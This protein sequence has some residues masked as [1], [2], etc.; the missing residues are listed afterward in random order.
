M[1][2]PHHQPTTVSRA[3]LDA[4]LDA[5]GHTIGTGFG[6]ARGFGHDNSMPPGL[7]AAPTWC[8]REA[9]A[10]RPDP[11]DRHGA[12]MREGLATVDRRLVVIAVDL[13]GIDAALASAIDAH[14][15]ECGLDDL[16]HTP[17]HNQKTN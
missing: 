9:A 17:I 11:H 4:A 8:E 12:A 16:T 13:D 2:E 5:L 15:A 6:R 14:L 3:V 7:G 10:S 1:P